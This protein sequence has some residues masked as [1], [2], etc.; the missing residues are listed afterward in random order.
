[1]KSNHTINALLALALITTAA[2]MQGAPWKEMW[3]WLSKKDYTPKIGERHVMGL[4]GSEKITI[5]NVNVSTVPPTVTYEIEFN[6]KTTT[7]PLETWNLWCG[8]ENNIKP[9]IPGLQVGQKYKH[10]TSEDILEVTG[11][12]PGSNGDYWNILVTQ[13]LSPDVTEITLSDFRKKLE[14]G[15]LQLTE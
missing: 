9:L 11:I 15:E 8:P 2:P 14:A 12:V 1:M 4:L 7:I 3:A 5:T 6:G 10:D 13:A